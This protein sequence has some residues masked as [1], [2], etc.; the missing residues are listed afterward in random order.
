[1]TLS[2]RNQLASVVAAVFCAFV[3][4][5]LSIAPAVAPATSVFA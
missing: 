5:G 3:T 1:M 4:V 2:T